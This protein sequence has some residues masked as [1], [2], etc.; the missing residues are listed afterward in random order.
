M[1]WY[2][3]MRGRHPV[4]AAQAV[5]MLVVLLTSLAILPFDCRQIAG[6]SVWIKPAKFA[7]SFALWFGTLAWLWPAIAPA[8]RQ[9][10]T[11]RLAVPV[12]LGAAWFE[13]AYIT[14]RAA[15][16]QGS[17][18][19]VG[20]LFGAVMYGLMGLGATMLVAMVA[21][22][23]L[24]IL[25]HGNPAMPALARRAAG[26][27]LL[28]TGILG[29]ATGWAISVHQGA[30]IGGTESNAGGLAP[31]FWSRDGGDLRVAHFMGMHAMQALPLAAW[32]LARWAPHRAAPA[33]VAAAIA[34]VL[35][36]V[37]SFSQ[38]TAGRP[39]GL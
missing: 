19:A 24:L 22:V 38:A 25:R 13:M 20:D 26:W 8:A 31:F 39:L 23:G 34:W 28:L 37:G 2:R 30:W 14:G 33:W 12:M 29:G 4:F 15:F 11:A 18:F 32:V 21:G 35:V 10:W 3:E 9:R 16:G 27:G 1:S 17:H 5:A 7:A 6:V 36:T